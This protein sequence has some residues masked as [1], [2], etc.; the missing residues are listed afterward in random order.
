MRLIAEVPRGR[1]ASTDSRGPELHESPG[2]ADGRNQTPEASL[3]VSDD[4]AE[5]MAA[6]R[7]REK[8]L[9]SSARH[10]F[11][12]EP[13]RLA[14]KCESSRTTFYRAG[15]LKRC[16]HWSRVIRNLKPDLV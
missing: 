3:A 9:G 7:G 15:S 1:I 4:S 13:V 12:I 11:K 8:L 5:K 16:G 2:A 6:N 10:G 14:A